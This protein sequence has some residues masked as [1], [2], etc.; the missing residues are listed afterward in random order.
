MFD[1]VLF[2]LSLMLIVMSISITLTISALCIMLVT[3]LYQDQNSQG[4]HHA[5]SAQSYHPRGDTQWQGESIKE[6]RDEQKS[7][8]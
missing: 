6:K 1:V 3:G 8:S 2:F 5:T 4:H 7:E